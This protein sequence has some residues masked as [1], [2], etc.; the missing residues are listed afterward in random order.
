MA[1]AGNFSA[2]T[3]QSH[4]SLHASRPAGG[5]N[6]T[7]N[8]EGFT[9]LARRILRRQRLDALLL[10]SQAGA[11]RPRRLAPA[12]RLILASGLF[13]LTPDGGSSP[14]PVRID[15]L[16]AGLPTV[17]RLAGAGCFRGI[18]LRADGRQ[19]LF[20]TVQGR[21]TLQP[22]SFLFY[23]AALLAPPGI[24]FTVLL[25]RSRFLDR[26]TGGHGGWRQYCHCDAEEDELT[27]DMHVTF[28]R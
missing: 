26:G 23:I 6:T 28:F 14:L 22:D 18:G 3:G 10:S 12:R 21:R 2:E 20:N 8:V 11:Y 16:S 25:R 1:F 5:S 9:P 24:P 13:M 17:A 27:P 15:L 4:G 19:V 7:W